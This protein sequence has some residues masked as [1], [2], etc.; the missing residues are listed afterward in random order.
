MTDLLHYGQR[1][2]ISLLLRGRTGAWVLVRIDAVTG[3]SKF[4]TVAVVKS[5]QFS[6]ILSTAAELEAGATESAAF[7][8]GLA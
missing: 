6:D 1:L 4:A 3:T 7:S 8:E 2:P 5:T